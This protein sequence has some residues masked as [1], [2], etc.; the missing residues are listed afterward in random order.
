MSSNSPHHPHRTA[1]LRTLPNKLTIARMAA[2]PLLLLLYPLNIPKLNIVCAV[3]FAAAAITDWVDGYV[4]RKYHAVTPLGALLDPIAD[5]MLV[6]AALVL[7]AYNR[8][9]PAFIAA[10]LICRDIGING[11]RLMALEQGRVIAVNEFGKWKTALTSVSIFCLM[12]NAPLFGLPFR[13]VGMLSLWVA[14][15]LSLYSAWLYGQAF[16]TTPKSATNRH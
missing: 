10:L 14:L 15:G 8:V 5:K 11:I 16:I 7:L 3:I 9:A 1:W 2:I 13:T 12:V 4:A 6:A